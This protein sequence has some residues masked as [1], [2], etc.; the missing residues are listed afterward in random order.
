[1][2]AGDMLF[3]TLT[4][5]VVLA[6]LERKLGMVFGVVFAIVAAASRDN[7]PWLV[8]FAMLSVAAFAVAALRPAVLAGPLRVWLAFGG[9]L[10]RVVS[11]V[12]LA[13]MYLLLIVPAG[14]LR[15][16]FGADPM[17]RKFE[18]GRTSYWVERPARKW[19]PDDFRQQ[20]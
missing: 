1:M 18:P 3:W 16:A 4:S 2:R 19:S 10:H 12:M 7:P 15:R 14:V 11:P 8:A 9:L 13:A 20:F 5:E 6:A 17:A